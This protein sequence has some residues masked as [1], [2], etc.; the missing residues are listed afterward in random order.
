MGGARVPL[1]GWGKPTPVNPLRWRQKDLA[2]VMVSIA[3]ILANILIAMIAF[4]VI[5]VLIVTGLVHSIRE[6][7]GAG[8]SVAG[9]YAD[10][11]HLARSL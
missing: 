9:I 6:A 4:I 5:K 1:N 2:N 10:D 8:H 3:G 7:S 11:E